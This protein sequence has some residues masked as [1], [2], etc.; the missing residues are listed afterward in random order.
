MMTSSFV[1]SVVAMDLY[2]LA[3]AWPTLA[4]DLASALS[5]SAWGKDDV[6]A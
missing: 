3:I 1:G 6:D 2:A 5:D 4:A